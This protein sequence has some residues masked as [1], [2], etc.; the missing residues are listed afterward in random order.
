M[1]KSYKVV[2]RTTT[3]EAAVQDALSEIE[4]LR[5]EMQEIVDNMEGANMEHLPKYEVANDALQE[6]DEHCDLSIDVPAKLQDIKITY[7]EMVNRRKGRAPSR[8][9]RLSNA[10][11]MLSAAIDA[12]DA[13][14]DNLDD[15]DELRQEIDEHT[16]ISVEF[17]GMFG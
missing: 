16:D 13:L 5:D 15:A 14:E 9:V 3:L 8:D 17:P 12:L 6:L 10:C 7:G 1:S 11:A 4:V 2:Q